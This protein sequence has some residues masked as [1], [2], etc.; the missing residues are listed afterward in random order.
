MKQMLLTLCQDKLCHWRVRHS[1]FNPANADKVLKAPQDSALPP[2]R[3][4]SV[5]QGKHIIR[6]ESYDPPLTQEGSPSHCKG[7][8]AQRNFWT[9]TSPLTRNLW[10]GAEIRTH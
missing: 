7:K 3:A 6:D 10:G 8:R 5:P 1:V 4:C 2:D 9:H